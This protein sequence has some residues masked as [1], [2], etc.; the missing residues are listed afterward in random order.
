MLLLFLFFFSFFSFQILLEISFGFYIFIIF[1]PQKLNPFH[2]IHTYQ[3]SM[4]K[5][6]E[7][8]WKWS[9]GEEEMMVEEEREE[10]GKIIGGGRRQLASRL[11]SNST[12]SQPVRVRVFKPCWHSRYIWNRLAIRQTIFFFPQLTL[13]H[14]IHS[15]QVHIHWTQFPSNPFFKEDT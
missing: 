7:V 6:W 13:N 2:P 8:N 3:N 5:S 14:M 11:R 12:Y 15:P 4:S 9:W 1:N 10:R